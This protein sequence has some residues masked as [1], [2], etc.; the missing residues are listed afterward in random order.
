MCKY[1]RFQLT[2]NQT[3]D[4]RFYGTLCSC[5]EWGSTVLGPVRSGGLDAWDPG[6]GAEMA[7]LLG[8]EFAQ[9]E[10]QGPFLLIHGEAFF[11]V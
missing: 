7:R 3:S 5:R 1:S 8:K 4:M 2:S 10:G 9:S 11:K 6:L